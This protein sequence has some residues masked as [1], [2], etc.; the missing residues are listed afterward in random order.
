MKSREKMKERK[1]T[2]KINLLE[3]L[4]AENCF[5]LALFLSHCLCV[6]LLQ[7]I[8]LLLYYKNKFSSAQIC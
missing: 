7:N 1:D 6:C 8:A 5:E 4:L 2:I 3:K